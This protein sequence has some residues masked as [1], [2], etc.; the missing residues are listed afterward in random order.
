M[1][2]IKCYRYTKVSSASSHHPSLSGELWRV[3]VTRVQRWLTQCPSWV[4]SMWEGVNSL[5]TAGFLFYLFWGIFL[6]YYS[7]F[8]FLSHWNLILCITRSSIKF[9]D[10]FFLFFFLIDSVALS[11][12]P[13]LFPLSHTVERFLFP[14][15]RYRKKKPTATFFQTSQ[16]IFAPKL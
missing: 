13:S 15:R 14:Q 6:I 8:S 16:A 11:L 9:F 1:S 10:F 12:F 3:W 5:W 4:L 7:A 2:T